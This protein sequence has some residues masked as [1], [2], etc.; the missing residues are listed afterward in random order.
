MH[1]T[2]LELMTAVELDRMR[3]HLAV[4]VKMLSLLHLDI[5]VSGDTEKEMVAV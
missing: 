1:V 5:G 3:E 4:V 2:L